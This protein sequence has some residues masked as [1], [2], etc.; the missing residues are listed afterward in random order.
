MVQDFEIVDKNTD[1]GY[2]AGYLAATFSLCQFVTGFGW[3]YLSDRYGRR[4]ILLF[5]LFSN[6]LTMS[7]FGLSKRFVWAIMARMVGGLLNG[8]MG[9]A[10]SIL[11]D[12]TDT[13]NRPF[14]F[15]LLGLMWGLGMIAGPIIGGFFCDPVKNIPFFKASLFLKEYPYFLPCFISSCIS[16][17]GFLMALVLLPETAPHLGAYQFLLDVETEE[18]LTNELM[19]P[20]AA[21][22]PLIFATGKN[23]SVSD[24]FKSLTVQSTAP[25]ESIWDAASEGIEIEDDELEIM[26]PITINPLAIKTIGS[27]ALLALQNVVFEEFFSVWAVAPIDNGLALHSHHIGS[28]LSIMGALTIVFQLGIYPVLTKQWSPYS[29]YQATLPIFML[30]WMGLPM[31]VYIAQ[32]PARKYL[33]TCLTILLGFRRFAIVTTYTSMNILIT[34]AATEKTMGLVNGLAQTAVSLVRGIGPII[35]GSIWSWSTE[36]SDGFISYTMVFFLLLA[37]NL[38]ALIHSFYIAPQQK[39][40]IVVEDY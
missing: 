25:I 21:A 36:H 37:L 15:S 12:I 32:E 24:I 20:P 13:S 26:D 30:V 28:I 27:Y 22:S 4:S 17:F 34:Q 35:G 10:K 33:I 7:C 6:A 11:A 8:N 23:A 1:I 19:I 29:I 9:I 14:A 16:I 40:E 18:E 39:F 3:G 2:Y 5:G 38:V 31:L